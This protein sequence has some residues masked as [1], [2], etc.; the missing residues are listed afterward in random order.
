[1]TL[2]GL[3]LLAAVP[4]WVVAVVIKLVAA[5]LPGRRPNQG[6]HLLRWCAGMAAAAAVGLYLIGAGAVQ[7]SEHDSRSGAD[8]WPPHS[9]RDGVP[10]ET[11]RRL[12]DYR[13]SY[14]PPEF[15]CVLDDGS[16]YASSP[17]Y[18][19]MNALMAGF[20]VVAAVLAVAARRTAATDGDLRVPARG[21][22]GA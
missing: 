17:G 11:M 5:V 21:A 15:D 4:I 7:Y 22:R 16:A 2:L 19:W 12:V 6:L 9:C 18:A 10:A 8:S 1:M 20:A 3:A 13:A 14:L